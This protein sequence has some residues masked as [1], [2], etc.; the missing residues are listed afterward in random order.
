MRLLPG[1]SRGLWTCPGQRG[2]RAGPPRLLVLGLKGESCSLPSSP[3]AQRPRG[4]G[5]WLRE[6]GQDLLSW[7]PRASPR[8]QLW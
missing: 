4:L 7:G 6:V 8:N 2:L 1:H 3:P 5:Q